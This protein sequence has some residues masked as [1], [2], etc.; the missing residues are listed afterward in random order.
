ME[1]VGVRGLELELDRMTGGHV[2]CRGFF[3]RL[4]GRVEKEMNWIEI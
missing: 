1:E 4:S 3:E 2:P